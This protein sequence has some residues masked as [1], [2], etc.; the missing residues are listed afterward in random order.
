MGS[1]ANSPEGL[2]ADPIL[3]RMQI[4]GMR[5]LRSNF[6]ENLRGFQSQNKLKKARS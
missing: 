4:V 2:G 1:C 3:T 5:P 6:V